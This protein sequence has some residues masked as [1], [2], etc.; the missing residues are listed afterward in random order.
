MKLISVEN[1][2]ISVKNIFGSV[3]FTSIDLGQLEGWI[4]K[5]INLGPTNF[6]IGPSPYGV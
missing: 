2:V 1:S 5:Q 6:N 3:F 4:F